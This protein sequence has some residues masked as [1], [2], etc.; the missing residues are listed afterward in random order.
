MLQATSHKTV[1][2]SPDE[3]IAFFF[4]LPNPSKH[5]M[6]LRLTQPLREIS[7]VNLSGE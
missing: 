1:G 7:T 6:A 4:N 3:V 2:S 5:F